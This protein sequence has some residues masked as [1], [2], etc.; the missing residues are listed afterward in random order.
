MNKTHKPSSIL[1][2]LHVQMFLTCIVY[3][4][5]KEGRESYI[6]GLIDGLGGKVLID[7]IEAK[8]SSI[9][10]AYVISWTSWEQCPSR[11]DH[12]ISW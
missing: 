6:G 8:L 3:V 5:Y 12:V 7:I 11:M 9:F 2:S 10:L 1:V 4:R